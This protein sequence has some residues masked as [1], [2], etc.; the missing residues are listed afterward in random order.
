MGN[1][2]FFGPTFGKLPDY[3]R[4][5][6]SNN[7]E[8]VADSWV[9]VQMSWVEVDGAGCTFSNTLSKFCFK[10]IISCSF[11][12]CFRI[13]WFHLSLMTS[14]KNIPASKRLNF[15]LDFFFILGILPGSSSTLKKV[16]KPFLRLNSCLILAQSLA[17]FSW[18]FSYWLSSSRKFSII[19]LIFGPKFSFRTNLIV[20][21]LVL[22][23]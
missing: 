19:G 7:V 21:I 23:F 17:H 14:S 3:V 10:A 13:L 2:E 5:F 16:L 11:I 6:G 4:Y 8:G 15:S 9:E 12:I 22:K 1:F 18:L 20:F